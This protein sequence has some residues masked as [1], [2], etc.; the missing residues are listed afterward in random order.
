MP[1]LADLANNLP[2]YQ[3][4]SGIGNFNANK[5][6]ADSGQFIVKK[7]GEK[8]N[9]GVS[10]TLT[11]FGIVTTVN[12]TLSDVSRISQ[13]MYTTPQ[14]VMFLAKQT[15]LQLT[16]PELEHDGEAL[17]TNKPQTGQGFFGNVSN[18]I[19]NFAN[20][21]SNDYGPTRIYNPLGTNTLAEVG[22]VASGIRFTKH[23]LVPDLNTNKNAYSDYILKKDKDSN[24]RLSGLIK[25]VSD[26]NFTNGILI[27]Y[28]GGPG[29]AFGIGNTNIKKANTNDRPSAMILT[30]VDDGRGEYYS[31]IPFNSIINIKDSILTIDKKNYDIG[32]NR[33]FRKI[34]KDNTPFGYSLTLPSSDYQKLNLE[35][36]IGIA[37][38]RTRLE[39]QTAKGDY[40]VDISGSSDHLNR[41]SLFYAE[42]VDAE[43][44]SNQLDIN[45]EVIGKRND[46]IKFR[47]KSYDNNSNSTGGVYMIFRAYLSNIKR[48]MNA[49]WNPYNYVGRGESFYLYDGFTESISFQ[50]TIMASSRGEMKPLYQKLNYLMSTL[51]P[52]YN[53]NNRM[54][55][56]ISELTIGDF[57][58]YQPG[59]I[60]NLDIAIDEDTNWEIA[61]SEPLGTEQR[62]ADMHELPHMLKCSM[63][64]IP[65]YNFLPR[66]S[67]EAPFIGINDNENKG[68]GKDWTKH[69]TGKKTSNNDPIYAGNDTD[70]KNLTSK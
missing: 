36:R 58:K 32:N 68:K 63:T 22:V 37:R 55:G 31:S 9:L 38:S 44:V 8:W 16:N 33:D 57:V 4:Y 26:P 30:S 45:N 53:S 48:S 54:R 19:S 56:N 60:T 39:N 15:G 70:L 20:K 18:S 27:S 10:D 50:F 65:I 41:I 11:P 69:D 64:F 2:N 17:P 66:K 52:D 21:A 42:N 3:Y 49:K 46:L 40:S 23:G 12:R 62:D 67:S 35:T 61:L 43:N 34:K 51:A 14:G 25:K 47:I 6:P 28:K 24:N 29:S 1:T 13:F 7:P 59:I 5:L